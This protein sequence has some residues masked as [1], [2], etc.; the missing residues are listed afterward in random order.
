MHA[1]QNGGDI[2]LAGDVDRRRL[3]Q[4]RTEQ[5]GRGNGEQRI[6]R[7]VLEVR[8]DDAVAFFQHALG[9]QGAERS[10]PCGP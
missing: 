7:P 1:A 6:A 10:D 9:H 3:R 8:Q 4:S 5:L 2:L